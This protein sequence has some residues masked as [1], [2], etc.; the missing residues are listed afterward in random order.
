M[1]TTERRPPPTASRPRGLPGARRHEHLRELPAARD[2]GQPRRVRR[3]GAAAQGGPRVH[4]GADDLL[5]LRVGLRAAGLRRQGRP[6]RSASSRAT[7]STPARRGRN[8]A[9]GPAT[10]NQINDPERILYPLR[11]VGERGAGQWERVHAGTRRSTTS[12]R[13]IRAAYRRGPP[14]RGHV[15]RRPARRGRL[16]RAGAAGLGRRRAQQPHQHLLV[17]RAAR[18]RALGRLRPPVARPRQRQVHPAA[19]LAPGDRPLLQPA[20]PADHGGQAGRR[21][22]GRDGPAAVQHRLAWPTLAAAVA[23]HRGR[24]PAGDRR[25]S[26]CAR[27]PYDREFLRRW[28]NWETY[29]AAPRIPT[30]SATF[31]SVP[32]PRSTADYARVHASSSPAAERGVPARADRG[33][34]RR[35]VAAAGTASRRTSGAP[36][37]RATSAAGR[38]RAACSSSTCSPGAVGTPGGTSPNGWDKFIAH[39]FDVPAGHDELERAALAAASTRSRTN[40]MSFLLPHFLNDGPRPARRLLHPRLQPGLDQPRR[41]HLDRGADRRDRRSACTSR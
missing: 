23:R 19:L 11:R 8:C 2:V 29:L 1:T 24:G 7:R 18:L 38:S 14:R 28:V 30:P 25:A 20:R 15:P 5:Q 12:P 13:R 27:G 9:K 41:L 3:E 39:G 26:C 35:S 40:E 31:D 4:A 32:R 22:A 6:A 21:Q 37:R 36:R 10:I 34:R 33:D 16:R 17:R